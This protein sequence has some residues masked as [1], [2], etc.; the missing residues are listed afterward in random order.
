MLSLESMQLRMPISVRVLCLELLSLPRNALSSKRERAVWRFENWW[1]WLNHWALDM[2]PSAECECAQCRKF[3]QSAEKSKNNECG[4]ISSLQTTMPTL[5][6]RFALLRRT[7]VKALADLE[8]AIQIQI[9]LETDKISDPELERRLSTLDQPTEEEEQ[10]DSESESVESS[11]ALS[12]RADINSRL[13]DSSLKQPPPLLLSYHLPITIHSIK[14]SLLSNL[15]HHLS[16]LGLKWNSFD[17][18][19][20]MQLIHPKQSWSNWWRTN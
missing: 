6:E 5:E 13:L 8:W 19:L 20:S 14:L 10:V 1:D 12:S 4:I 15:S 11:S 3:S 7:P 16:A 17:H 9:R 2:M 18:L